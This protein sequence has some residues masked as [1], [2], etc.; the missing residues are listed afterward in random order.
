MSAGPF[1]EVPILTA[2]HNIFVK[3]KYW[4]WGFD[5]MENGAFS[6]IC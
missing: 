4:F 3:K 2:E 6:V 1:M 5:C